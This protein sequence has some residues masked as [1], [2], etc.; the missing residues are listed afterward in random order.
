MQFPKEKSSLEFSKTRQA[1]RGIILSNS[2]SQITKI[3]ELND[4]AVVHVLETK[5]TDQVT[6]PCKFI[7]KSEDI[8]SNNEVVGNLYVKFELLGENGIAIDVVEKIV[9]LQKH[10]K[11]FNTPLKPPLIKFSKFETLSKAWYRDWE[12]DTIS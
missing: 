6:V 7:L 3:D 11:I 1:F 9:D 5:T 2:D 8:F 12:T 10:I 4:N